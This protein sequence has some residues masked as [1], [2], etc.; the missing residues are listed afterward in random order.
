MM[1]GKVVSCRFRTCWDRVVV[2]VCVLVWVP[3]M[4]TVWVLVTAVVIVT[5][6]VAEPVTLRETVSVTVLG[7]LTRFAGRVEE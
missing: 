1:D 7:M 6:E 2:L 3:T 4:T 5:S